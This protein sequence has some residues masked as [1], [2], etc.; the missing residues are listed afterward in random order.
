[1]RDD[2]V[3]ILLVDDQPAKL[4]AYE[5]MLQT[6]D[7]NL[8]KAN[9]AREALEM[10]LKT[11]VAV[12]LMDVSMPELDGF[13]LAAM[14]RN[15]PRFQRTAIIFV[16]AI[17]LSE[18]DFL[19]GYQMGA[20]DYVSV[21]VVPE[22]LRAKVRVFAELY[23]KTRELES[24]NAGLEARVKERTAALEQTA[25]RL[26]ESE[27]RRTLA[28]AAGQMGSWDWDLTSGDVQWD[29]GQYRILGVT[30]QTFPITVANLRRVIYPA[31]WPQLETL[32]RKLSPEAPSAQAEFRVRRSD[33]ELRWCFGTAAATIAEDGRMERISGVVMDVTERKRTEEQQALLVR[34]VDHRAKNVLAVV[35]SIVRLSRASS[36]DKYVAAIEGR[37]QALSR[38]HGLIARS[39]WDGADLRRLIEEELSPYDVGGNNVLNAEGAPF[40][41]DPGTAQAVALALHE[42]TTNAA[43]YGALSAPGGTIDI[44]WQEED[45]GLRLY[46]TERGGPPAAEPATPGFGLKVISRTVDAQLGGSVDFEWH[47]D[48]LRCV[49]TIPLS[50]TRAANGAHR[51][52]GKQ[53]EHEVPGA[54]RILLVEDEALVAIMMSDLLRAKGYSV[55]GPLASVADALEPAHEA[56]LDA[57]LLDVTLGHERIYPVAEVLAARGIPFAFLTGYGRDGID[58]KFASAPVLQKPVDEAALDGFL[59]TAARRPAVDTNPPIVSFSSPPAGGS[60]SATEPFEPR[61]GA[62]PGDAL[63]QRWPV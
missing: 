50:R 1:V 36:V 53:P 48:G 21:P 51:G 8:L 10:L 63:R 7:E 58:P 54:R 60:E 42:L 44:K 25:A 9:S 29:E 55:V 57:A 40:S 59:A 27:Q 22:V 62:S 30:P 46:W 23:R 19:R 26:R 45:G 32:I 3:N 12:V 39:R 4:L 37:I 41:L 43:K 13:E 2:R 47:R 5:V 20:V 35:Q 6:I 17:H 56:T 16:S 38:V 31:D 61:S 49:F 28:L 34:E 11:D 33:G 24:L 14:V 18:V 52:N 15:H